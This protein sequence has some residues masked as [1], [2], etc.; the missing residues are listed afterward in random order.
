MK[1]KIRIDSLNERHV[2]FT[3]F[4]D[5]GNCGHLTMNTEAFNQ[6][7][8]TLATSDLNVSVSDD[9]LDKVAQSYL[10]YNENTNQSI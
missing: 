8:H 1:L 6:Y 2:R 7:L 4:Q 9:T 3:I 5:G 10:E